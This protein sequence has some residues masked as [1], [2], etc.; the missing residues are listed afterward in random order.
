VRGGITDGAGPW[1]CY[2]VRHPAKGYLLRFAGA[3]GHRMDVWVTGRCQ[4]AYPSNGSRRGFAAE[5]LLS[6]LE[7][8]AGG[9]G[10][11]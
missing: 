4:D 8:L 2:A 10:F 1:A 11:S 7:H 6:R 9:T 3:D 5:Q